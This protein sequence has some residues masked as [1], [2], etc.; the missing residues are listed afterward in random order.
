MYYVI[1]IFVANLLFSPN[2]VSYLNIYLLHRVA[3]FPA[4]AAFAVTTTVDLTAKPARPQ[5]L[6][7]TEAI[8]RGLP[9]FDDIPSIM[10]QS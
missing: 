7:P 9:L 8:P 10:T 5:K 6:F 4:T 1:K 3:I 2:V